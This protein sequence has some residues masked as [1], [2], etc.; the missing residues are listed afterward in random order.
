MDKKPWERRLKDLS[1]LLNSC[2]KTYF[3]PELF[4]LNLNQFLQ[5]SRTVTFIIQK[6]KRE[7]EDYDTWYKKNIIEKWSNDS[8]MTWA[9]NSR[10]TIEKQGDLEMYSEAKATLISSYI[11]ENDIEITTQESLLG[12]GI[13][14]LVRVAQKKLPSALTDTAVIK[15]E[16]RWIA[17][18]LKDYELLQALTIIYSR[19]YECCKSLGLQVGNPIDKNIIE[20]TSFD[21]LLNE[22]KRITY[23]K[24]R[25]YSAGKLSFS[26][27]QYDDKVISET[28]KERIKSIEKPDNIN[29]TEALV[30]YL[31]KIAEMAFLKDGFHIQTLIFYNKDFQPIDLLNTTFEDQSDK[32]I[33][34]RY[35]ADR[36]KMINA[37]GFIWI[38]ELWIRLP[39][40][41]LGEAIHK[42]PI[43]DEKLQIIGIDAN[44]NQKSISWK[45]IR[46]ND[47]SKPTLETFEID[48]KNAG[49]PYFMRSVLKAIGGDINM[50]ND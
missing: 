6:N 25:N 9:K 31:S 28:V 1:H 20:P 30:D 27:V 38:S 36:A 43:I 10:N 40:S 29:S 13:K 50:L 23:L 14:K 24:I 37:Y 19:M 5:T 12:I 46:E 47:D 35:A 4:R 42:M 48:S 15:S 21:S 7:I 44:N 39:K 32:Y 8:L 34:W 16:R 18:T 41:H 17:N 2:T 26:T 11:E 49:K 33:F 22:T 45:I 3:D